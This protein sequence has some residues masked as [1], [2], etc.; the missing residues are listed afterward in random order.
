MRFRNPA[1][2]VGHCPDPASARHA[3]D[4]VVATFDC[5]LRFLTGRV[6]IN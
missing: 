4:V 5:R 2:A 3:Q 6:G 1:L